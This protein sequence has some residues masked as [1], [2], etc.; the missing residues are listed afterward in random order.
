[1]FIHHNDKLKRQAGKRSLVAFTRLEGAVLCSLR[2]TLTRLTECISS[3]LSLLTIVSY[4]KS[5]SRCLQALC[6]KCS[7]ATAKPSGS[8]VTVFIE[9]V[10]KHISLGKQCLARSILKQ[11]LLVSPEPLKQIMRHKVK[12]GSLWE[13]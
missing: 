7:P 13:L 2:G 5:D 1:M 6:R 12:L 4:G 10:M 3:D 11:M 8:V 9:L